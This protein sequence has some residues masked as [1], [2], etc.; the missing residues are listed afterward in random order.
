V[1]IS[2]K[3]IVAVTRDGQP[4]IENGRPVTETV[5]DITRPANYETLNREVVRQQIAK[6]GFRLAKLLDAI[7]Q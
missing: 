3:R 2:R 6:G 7:F 4:V 5:Y 1:R